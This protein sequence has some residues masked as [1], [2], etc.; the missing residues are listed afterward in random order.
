M[1]T[2]LL[3]ALP[4]AVGM[5]RLTLDITDR[6]AVAHSVRW[7]RFDTVI[8]CAAYNQVDRAEQ[9]IE[10]CRSVN[11]HGPR[12][13]AEACQ[14]ERV[15]L[16]HISTDYVFGQRSPHRTPWTEE[17]VPRPAGVYAQTKLAGESQVARSERHLIVRTCGLYGR[18]AGRNNFVETM[19]RLADSREAIRVVNDQHCTPTSADDLASAIRFLLQVDSAGIFHVVNHGQTTWWDFAEEIFRIASL[20]RTLQPITAADFASPAPRPTFSVLDTTRYDALGG[21]PMRDWRDALRAYM[22]SRIE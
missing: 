9:D 3:A 7:P 15:R 4:Q 12:L 1:G 8:N 6:D 10:A 16:V 5:G 14:R 21:P 19:L 18:S 13:L 11:E 22:H 20:T 17:D 2:A